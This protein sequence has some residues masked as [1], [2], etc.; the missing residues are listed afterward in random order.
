[1]IRL[2]Y[3][4]GGKVPFYVID[5]LWHNIQNRAEHSLLMSRNFAT[6]QPPSPNC[7]AKMDGLLT[8]SS[9]NHILSSPTCMTSFMNG[10]LSKVNLI[11]IRADTEAFV[12]LV[13]R[14]LHF[15][16]TC[17]NKLFLFSFW[18]GER[19]TK[20]KSVFLHLKNW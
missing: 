14:A 12:S 7:H 11:V 15:L 18:T 9:P 16:L 2:G 10:S 6:N 8:S 5:A 19:K 17:Q 13:R 20:S 3:G 1:M 4:G